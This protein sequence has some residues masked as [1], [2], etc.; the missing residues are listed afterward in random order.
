MQAIHCKVA[1]ETETRRFSINGADYDQLLTFISQL[2]GVEKDFALKYKDE[3]GDYVSISSSEELEC[4][5]EVIGDDLLRLFLQKP[6]QTLPTV[7]IPDQS[8]RCGKRP[9]HLRRSYQ[10]EEFHQKPDNGANPKAEFRRAK[11]TAKLENKK[12]SIASRIAE[13]DASGSSDERLVAKKARLE[14]KMTWISQGLDHLSGDQTSVTPLTAAE[15]E[16]LLVKRA[17]LQAL[18]TEKRYALR[19]A[20]LQLQVARTN[21]RA[22]HHQ[23][24]SE[25]DSEEGKAKLESLKQALGQ[26]KAER[27]QKDVEIKSLYFQLKDLDHTLRC[28]G[29]SIPSSDLPSDLFGNDEDSVLT[30]SDHKRK[31]WKE[32]AK[33]FKKDC[34]AH[35]HRK[36]NGKWQGENK[37]TTKSS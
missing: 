6:N 20:F 10:K 3:E 29:C 13:L 8:T 36:C 25:H 21:L 26:A 22:A 18:V 1:A 19:Q 17:N 4:A 33:R 34:K 11:R 15:M 12:A 24:G 5:I 30:E 31:P 32:D 23:L 2:F 37:K 28:G 27:Q 16:E 14:N 7:P 35:K 9:K